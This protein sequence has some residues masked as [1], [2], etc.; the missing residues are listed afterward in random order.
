MPVKIPVITGLAVYLLN[1]ITGWLIFSGVIKISKLAHRVLFAALI[2]N[3]ALITLLL[4]SSSVFFYFC[5]TSLVLIS[6]LPY[7]KNGGRFHR[8]ISTSGLLF[9]IIFSITFFKSN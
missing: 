2:F 4:D 8:Y 6:L 9:Y 1:Y 3:L 5:G 7:G